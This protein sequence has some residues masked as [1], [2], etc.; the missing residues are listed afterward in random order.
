MPGAPIPPEIARL[1]RPREEL[2]TWY[3]FK[4]LATL[5]AFPVTMLVFYFRYHTMRY[6]FDEEGIHMS[7]GILMRHEIMLNYSRIQDIQLHSN[8]IERWLGL[9]RIE[10]QTAAGASDSEMTLEGLPNPEAMRDFLYSRMR[11]AHTAAPAAA[12]AA[13]EPLQAVLLEVASELRSIREILEARK[14]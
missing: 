11:G 1:E 5:L 3:F 2:L 9:M 12:N 4:A 13:P 10:V 8:V 14:A 7:W 6:K